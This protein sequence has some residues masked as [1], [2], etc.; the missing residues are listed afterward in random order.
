MPL[1]KRC[2][3]SDVYWNQVDGKWRLHNSDGLPHL[4]KQVFE[5]TPVQSKIINSPEATE[6][7]TQ[8][9][10]PVCGQ[11]DWESVF[12]HELDHLNGHAVWCGY[13]KTVIFNAWFREAM[14]Y[15]RNRI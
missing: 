4:C 2:G 14:H 6:E 10:C 3:S 13:C 15:E 8:K 12:G 11:V 9:V 5:P 7:S 1:C